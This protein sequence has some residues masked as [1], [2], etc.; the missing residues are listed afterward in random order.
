MKVFRSCFPAASHAFFQASENFIT[1]LDAVKLN[2][3][4]VDEL[5]PLVRDLQASIVSI[6]NLPPLA[7]VDRIAGWLVTLNGMRARA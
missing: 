7:G 4:A 1:L 6:P 3:K 2:L 5:L